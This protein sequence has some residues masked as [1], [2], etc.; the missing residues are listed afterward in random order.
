M[1]TTTGVE[2]TRRRRTQEG[3]PLSFDFGGTRR[4]G[5]WTNSEAIEYFVSLLGMSPEEL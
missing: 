1:F 5:L 3:L 2:Q 4:L